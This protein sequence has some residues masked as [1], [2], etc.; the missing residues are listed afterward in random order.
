[1]TTSMLLKNK[2]YIVIKEAILKEIFK[3]GQL[4]SEKQL[5][6]YLHMSKT[7]IKSALERLET[8][9]FVVVSPKQGILVK[10]VSLQ[11]LQDLF[12]LRI[13]LELFV[14]EKCTGNLNQL[15]CEKI[16]ENL[17]QQLL[18][19]Q[20]GNSE[21]FTVADAVFHILFYEFF[22]NKEILQIMQKN[23]D[24]FVQAISKIICRVPNR[25]DIAYKEHTL[26]YEAVKNKK[27]PEIRKLISKHLQFAKEFLVY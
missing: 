7:P 11:K 2:A 15:Q 3:S 16:E 21:Q 4:L 18:F 19:S 6:D 24:R 26:I 12:D 8:E 13:A 25:I 20:E 27:K 1:M 17:S 22:G 10:E 14:M 23:Q 9:D 5:I